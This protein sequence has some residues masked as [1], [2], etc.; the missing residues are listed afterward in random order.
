[1]KKEHLSR[2][3][4]EEC[5]HYFKEKIHEVAMANFKEDFPKKLFTENIENLTEE[6]K[7]DRL[8]W[9]LD[10]AG[11]LPIPISDTVFDGLAAIR[12]TIRGEYPEAALSALSAVPWFA[13]GLPGLET[14]FK[15]GKFHLYK[16]KA[17][18]E[19]DKASKKA[20]EIGKL[21]GQ[22]EAED[23]AQETSKIIDQTKEK[24]VSMAPEDFQKLIDKILEKNKENDGLRA[25]LKQA[26]SVEREED[27]PLLEP[28]GVAQP[29][30]EGEETTA[31]GLEK[32]SLPIREGK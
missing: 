10:I 15:A 4:L 9:F 11:Y 26:L 18:E 13:M 17:A 31:P 30:D 24:M 19:A 6:E 7:K 12:H 27:L 2:V 16:K 20:L 28:I 8:K 23:A 1:M 32:V 21:S 22:K 14:A 29:E 5:D 3:I 25:E